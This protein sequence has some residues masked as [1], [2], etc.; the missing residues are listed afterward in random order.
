MWKRIGAAAAIGMAVAGC[1]GSAPS[2]ASVEAAQHACEFVAPLA[3]SGSACTH[4]EAVH[5]AK[6]DEEVEALKGKVRQHIN[7]RNNERDAEEA[8]RAEE[9]N[10]Q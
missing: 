9:R 7:E 10:N 6:H 5:A 4:E 1:G 8:V 2:Q 3:G